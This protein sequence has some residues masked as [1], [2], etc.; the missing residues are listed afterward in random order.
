MEENSVA[1]KAKYGKTKRN[2]KKQ[3]YFFN[4][5]LFVV[6]DALKPLNTEGIKE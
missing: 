4:C 1:L 5:F 6:T 3:V 2:K